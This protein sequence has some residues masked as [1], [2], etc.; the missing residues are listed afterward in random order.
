MLE[1]LEDLVEVLA[2]PSLGLGPQSLDQP[3]SVLIVCQAV[4]EHPHDLVAPQPAELRRLGHAC[5]VRHTDPHDD[6]A[7]VSEVEEVVALVGSRQQILQRRLVHL[8]GCLDGG[9]L[10]ALDGGG[11]VVLVKGVLHDGRE[12]PCHHLVVK[13]RDAD[14]VEPAE[15]AGGDKRPPSSR[16]T[17][18]R[19]V[20]H[21]FDLHEALLFQVVPAMMIHVLPQDLDRGLSPVRLL[22]GHVEVIDEGD[23]HFADGGAQHSLPPLVKLRLDD[24]LRLV[25]GG[26][27]GEAER[28][29]VELVRVQSVEQVVVDVDGLAGPRGPA[30][31]E[32]HAVQ[33]VGEAAVLAA[34]VEQVG[35]AGGVDGG[36]DDL[37]GLKV[38]VDGMVGDQ[39]APCRPLALG[40]VEVG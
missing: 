21:V 39:R 31:Q 29:D 19:H 25:G 8:H 20:H 1:V 16:R 38:G 12:D 30:Q 27:G 37:V 22:L 6:S 23:A 9:V 24:L 5:R 28:D 13:L 17:H 34:G 35:V 36:D 11:G 7:E 2:E 4:V 14:H 10:Q 32:S 15:K 3:L 26:L 40:C 33:V 18:S